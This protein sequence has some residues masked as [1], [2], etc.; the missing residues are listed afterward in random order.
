MQEPKRSHW[1]ATIRVVKYLK[2]ALG[3]GVFM[4]AESTQHLTCW[5]DSDWATC[6]NTKR[7]MTGYVVKFGESLV[8]WKSKK[9]QTISRSSAE[10][11]YRSMASAV[12]EV[13]WLLGLFQELGVVIT[14]PVV[15]RKATIQIAANPIFHER[16]K[17]IKLSATLFE[18][19]SSKE[20][21]SLPSLALKIN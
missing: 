7:S 15:V 11:E 4:K 20:S 21:Y 14:Q 13:T 9:Q 18:I 17:H 2:N 10:A 6:P 19:R 8:S 5:C 3:L 1:E 12:A 16:T